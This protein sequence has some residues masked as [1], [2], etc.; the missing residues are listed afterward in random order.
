MGFLFERAVSCCVSSGARARAAAACLLALALSGCNLETRPGSNGLIVALDSELSAPKDIDR[1][2]LEVTQPGGILRFEE[3]ALGPAGLDLPAEFRFAAPSGGEPVLIRFT[4][5]KGSGA[6]IERSAFV[7]IPTEHIGLLR[8]ALNF[9][10]AGAIGPD[11]GS[12][13][14]SERTCHQGSCEAITLA[15][16]EL[17][18][19]E[20]ST[21]AASAPDGASA[22]PGCFDVL[23]CL[24]A[25]QPVTLDQASCSFSA[26]P[27]TLTGF[28]NVA[29]KLSPGGDGSCDA[30]G[31]WVVLDAGRDTR[32]G[33]TFDG[34]TIHL[35]PAICLR[36]P[37][38]SLT[39]AWS[40]RCQSKLSALHVC[41]PALA[42]GATD[43][44]GDPIRTPVGESCEGPGSQSCGAC[45]MQ[46]RQCQA[47][48]WSLWSPCSDQGACTS[49]S[50][51]A[52]GAS[53]MQ[54]CGAECQWSPCQAQLCEGPA[55]RACGNC[56]T[57]H[58]SCENGLWSEWSPCSGEGECTP[59]TTQSCGASGTQTCGGNCR[60]ADCEN[61]V[62][63]GAALQGCG[64][65]GS[66]TRECNRRSAKWSDW[67]ACAGEG[68]C[69]PNAA[70]NCGS[71]GTQI[72][73]GDCR[74]DAACSGQV[75]SGPPTRRCGH[76]GIQTRVCNGNT[77]FWS[78]WSQC[79]GEG[80]CEPDDTRGCGSGGTQSCDATCRWN[81]SC[82][83]QICR[84]EAVRSCGNCGEQTRSC[85]ADTG[86]W[87]DWSRCSGEGACAPGDARGCGAGGT[88][89]CNDN[90]F[91]QRACSG[92]ICSGAAT[93]TCGNCGTQT[94]SC[95]G[96]SGRWSDWSACAEEGECAPGSS[97]ACGSNGAQ[98]CGE[99][100]RWQ[101]C[102]FSCAPDSMRSCGNCGTQRSACDAA[103]GIVSWSECGGQG[104]CQPGTSQSCGDHARQSCE[105]ACSRGSCSCDTG[106]DRCRESCVDLQTDA[107]HCGACDQACPAG[108]ICAAASCTQ[109][110]AGN[111]PP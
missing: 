30:R 104:D 1:L 52:C 16:A 4:A 111:L 15:A 5:Y 50:A 9:L 93:Q 73:G 7:T 102:I 21:S 101:S 38:L 96:N 79:S 65:C 27:M 34:T 29:F 85:D 61:Q 70:R 75:C 6:R 37:A 20:S 78:D 87:S 35:P 8:L 25:S 41:P 71:S 76:C 98:S 31:C 97:Q 54:T 48:R 33:W 63:A 28:G 22:G 106:F 55:T 18:S 62:C 49:G 43:P 69:A 66:R 59:D 46:A 12:S 95:D 11:G 86:R 99:D 10:C 17:P 80:E 109:A 68:S 89:R 82:S 74:W 14:G 72:C 42:P 53:G 64:N 81:A 39:L 57:Q 84:G 2:R 23:G 56:G 3:H 108:T 45:G 58:R 51:Q 36:G 19:Y 105:A 77:G 83:G 44:A 107:A 91:W 90:C 88:Q 47:G 32:E 60:W 100:C 13:C 103:T 26:P 94:R 40:G 92:Q 67:S 110:D 24:S